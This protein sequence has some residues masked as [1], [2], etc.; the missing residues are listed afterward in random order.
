MF[1]LLTLILLCFVICANILMKRHDIREID[2]LV[3]SQGAL[4]SLIQLHSLT[5]NRRPTVGVKL[6]KYVYC[7][8]EDDYQM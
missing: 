8:R 4:S 1:S 7:F 3:W 6:V 5:K 2:D